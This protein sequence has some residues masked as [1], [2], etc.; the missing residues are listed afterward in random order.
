[1]CCSITR[2]SDD[3]GSRLRIAPAFR[4]GVRRSVMGR[5]APADTV[6]RAVA[7]FPPVPK[8]APDAAVSPRRSND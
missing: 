3:A 6:N 1:M 2:E 4:V 8:I 5:T 7:D